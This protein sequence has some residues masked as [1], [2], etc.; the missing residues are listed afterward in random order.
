MNYIQNFIKSR[1]GKIGASDIPTLIQHPDRYDSLAGY[2]NTPLTL[3]QEK[4]G[5]KQRE[6]SGYSAHIGHLLEP[7]V[8][9]EWLLKKVDKETANNFYKGYILCELDKT[10]EGYPTASATQYT[11]FLHH[12]QASNDFAIAHAD[13]INVSD[14]SIIE[15]KT[16]NYWSIQRRN[17]LYNGYDFDIKGHQGIP[18]RNYYQIQFHR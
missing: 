14:M 7:I 17:D 6:Q 15:A 4:T 2:G 9:Y 1:S 10:N 16:A 18:L 11:N 8:L 3:W 12:T 5:Q 13:M